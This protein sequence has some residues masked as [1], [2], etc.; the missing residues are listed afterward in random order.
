MIQNVPSF[1]DIYF[2]Y[3]T[4]PC[5]DDISGLIVVHYLDQNRVH[6]L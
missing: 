4:P 5:Y 1:E 2:E 6:H 3:I